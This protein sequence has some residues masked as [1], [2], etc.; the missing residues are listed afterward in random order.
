MG[1]YSIRQSVKHDIV[2]LRDSFQFNYGKAT[3]RLDPDGTYTLMA[4][5]SEYSEYVNSARRAYQYKPTVQNL[6]EKMREAYDQ[7]TFDFTHL[8]YRLSPSRSRVSIE[9]T[10]DKLVLQKYTNKPFAVKQPTKAEI[11][12]ELEY[13]AS[14][15]YFKTFGTNTKQ[16]EEY[17][18]AHLQD[19]LD[20]R[21]KTWQELS[22][23]H[24]AIQAQ[25]AE[26]Q[27]LIY[28]KEYTDKKEELENI[29]S[30]PT[31]F[32]DAEIRKRLSDIYLPFD[33]ELDY[34]YSKQQKQLD[35][36]V[37]VP[38][39]IPI[40][41]QKA[42]MLASGKVSIKNKTTKEQDADYKQ[43]IY[44][45]TYY[46]A[47]KFFDV[48]TNIEKISVTVWEEGKKLGLIWVEFPR[49]DFNDL[50]KRNRQFD[51]VFYITIGEYYSPLAGTS[52]SSIALNSQRTVFLKMI[53]DIKGITVDS[54]T[55]SKTAASSKTSRSL[56]AD[57]GSSSPGK[58]SA[59]D[60]G[61]LNPDP[62]HLTI[63]EANYLSSFVNDPELEKQVQ[64]AVWA[65]EN[66][67]Q[68]HLKYA[69]IW[70]DIKGG[71]GKR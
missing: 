51:P 4:N 24:D 42:T 67:V 61:D 12:A 38:L 34:T 10:L 66:T 49:D 37:E 71:M 1:K 57:A 43:C 3:V 55:T 7:Q 17:V 5:G 45:L 27:N 40:P 44:G 30:G 25:N 68:I 13:E 8:N 41:F 64:D 70:A 35:V 26:K 19:A 53:A 60:N 15:L 50:V 18:N 23:Y 56:S 6:S 48:S 32:V 65:G 31:R 54:G 39:S 36:E 29:L 11:R 69:G 14:Q 47:S 59:F 33:I 52:R 21:L 16:I 46:I 28:F 62:F 9:N 58:V 20:Q 22:D 63:R 2:P